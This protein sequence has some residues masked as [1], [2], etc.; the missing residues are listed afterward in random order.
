MS[1]THC[2]LSGCKVILVTLVLRLRVEGLLR[3]SLYSSSYL[4]HIW[5]VTEQNQESYPYRLT[6]Y[7]YYSTECRFEALPH[8]ASVLGKQFKLITLSTGIWTEE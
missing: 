6:D 2:L 4:C 7:N 5:G 3:P 1:F 8:T